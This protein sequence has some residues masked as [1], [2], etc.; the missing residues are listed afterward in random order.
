METLFKVPATTGA[1]RFVP[2]NEMNDNYRI[3]RLSI[4]IHAYNEENSITSFLGHINEVKL[5]C[6]LEKDAII[7]NNYSADNT[8]A[9]LRTSFANT[10]NLTNSYLKYIQHDV[11]AAI[12]SGID[13]TM[14]DY[15]LIQDA[16]L[17][18]DPGEYNTLL[19]PILPGS[20]NVEYGSRFMGGWQS[21][22]H[23]ILLAF[24]WKPRAY[25]FLKYV[26][27]FEPD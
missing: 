14:V 6:N 19:K 3:R 1:N 9:S 15:P 17:K 22:P 11:N 21:T 24:Y 26:Q 5:I 12:H 23:P 27:Q 18:Y 25:L 4:F 7:V 20:A 2:E 16:D 13:Q 8:E 10:P